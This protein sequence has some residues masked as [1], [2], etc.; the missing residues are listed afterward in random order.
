MQAHHFT[1]KEVRSLTAFGV[2]FAAVVYLF[3]TFIGAILGILIMFS[4]VALIVLVLNPIVSGLERR[5][6]PR[7]ISAT[8]IAVLALSALGILLWLAVPPAARQTRQFFKF[9]PAHASK[10]QKWA[11]RSTGIGD[12]GLS[13][14]D[15]PRAIDVAYTRTG[16]VLSRIGTYTLSAVTV[17]VSGF[18]VFIS[19]IYVLASPRPIVEGALRLLRP[20]QSERVTRVLTRISA[21]MRRWTLAMAA[22]MTAIFVLTYVLLGPILKL[23]FAFLFSV[24]AGLLEIVPTVGP[25]LSAIPPL[26][27][28]LADEPIKAVWVA[29]GFLLIQQIENNLLIPLILGGGLRLH[30]VSVIFAL[31]VMGGLFGIVGV[32]LAVPALVVVKICVEEFY[33]IPKEAR[34]S[35]DVSEK[36]EQ[37]VSG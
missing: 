15:L 33:L 24:I 27:V 16:P 12:G 31:L 3:I 7:P 26:V 17:I 6:V 2:L 1:P 36:V 4:L 10:A 35:H 14:I 11:V 32:F 23:P 34:E 37:I 22:G 9:L 21:Q 13:K 19:V 18:I 8:A 25:V 29:A 28:A 5:R 30:P 20:D